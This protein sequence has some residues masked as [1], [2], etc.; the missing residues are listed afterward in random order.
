MRVT[1]VLALSSL[2]FKRAKRESWPTRV[3]HR[4]NR[5]GTIALPGKNFWLWYGQENILN[6]TYLGRDLSHGQ[7]DHNALKWLRNFKQ[8]KGVLVRW[9]E[10]LTRFEFQ[11][12]ISNSPRGWGRWALWTNS[13]WDMLHYRFT[14]KEWSVKLAFPLDER[15][16]GAVSKILT[17]LKP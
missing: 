12:V 1:E 11:G 15:R 7:L 5:R 9:L 14:R 3:K 4:L 13:K 17:S 6:H 16:N 10:R 8:P 2:K